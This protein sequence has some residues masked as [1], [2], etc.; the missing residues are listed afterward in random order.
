METLSE[1]DAGGAVQLGY[2][3]AFGTVDDEGASRGHVRDGAEEDILDHGVEIFVFG[4]G[5]VQLELR[6]ERHTVGETAF[7]A[8][9]NGVARRIHEI[10]EELEHEIVA[11]VRDREHLLEYFV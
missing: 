3:D 4:V 1:E 5:A 7:E 6:L 11:G 2:N 8:L 10:I 9:F